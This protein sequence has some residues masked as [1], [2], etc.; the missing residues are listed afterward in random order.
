MLLKNKKKKKL[1]TRLLP[2]KNQIL[3][4]LSTWMTLKCS[5]QLQ[6]TRPPGLQQ[7]FNI[8]KCHTVFEVAG[9]DKSK[10]TNPG[11]PGKTSSKFTVVF[12]ATKHRLY[13][14]SSAVFLTTKTGN[15]SQNMIISYVL[16][17]P[18]PDQN[19]NTALSSFTISVVFPE[20]YIG[21][22]SF[23]REV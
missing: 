7:S 3:W 12:V 16:L 6:A 23:D 11:V 21:F 8:C 19:T 2:S 10:V 5:T 22:Y 14:S 17:V 20:I 18:K 9:T 13:T 15:L 1:E 4:I